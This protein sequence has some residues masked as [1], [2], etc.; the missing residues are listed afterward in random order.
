[1]IKSISIKDFALINKKEIDFENGFNV[2]TGETGAGKSILISAINFVLGER[3]DKSKIR[4]GCDCAQVQVVFETSNAKVLDTL[5]NFGFETDNAI[6]IN[7]K[8][9]GDGHSDIRLNGNLITLSMLRKITTNLVDVYGQ[10]EH[11]SL[12]DISKHIEYLDEY[13]GVE[14]FE[15][16]KELSI[17]FDEMKIVKQKINSFGGDEY[18]RAREKDMLLYQVK[19]IEEADLKAEEEDELLVLKNK[20]ENCQ[21]IF[22]T[23][24]TTRELLSEMPSNSICDNLYNAS[25]M[26]GTI[27]SIDSEF[28]Q[29]TERLNS[30]QIEAKDIAETLEQKIDEYNFNEYDFDKVDSRLDLIKNL[31]RKYGSSIDEILTFYQNSKL[32]LNEL[33]DTEELLA[34]YLESEDKLNKKIKAKCGELAE[35]RKKGAID[36]EKSIT[37]ELITLGM[38]NAKFCIDFKEVA[39]TINGTDSIEFMFSA[40]LG[41]PFKP[42]SK[43]ISGGEMSRFMLAFKTVMG[44]IE[45]VDTMIF[46]EIDSGMSGVTSITVG[47]KMA[48]LSKNVQVFAIT[49]LATIASFADAHYQIYK[50]VCGDKTVSNIVKL[51]AN[52]QLQEISRLAGGNTNSKIGLEHARELRDNAFAFISALK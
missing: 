18:S 3:A 32:R 30:I 43:V 25:K 42:L 16:K 7:R 19:E 2:I 14:V 23:V 13:L 20:M 21:R 10:H 29:L 17:L 26:L 1:M 45:T 8:I 44:N 49:H 50:Q 33:E 27:N 38:P 39:P 40:N 48:V 52:S 9:Y 11:Q 28:E 47:Q 35:I 34:K 24:R 6:I 46:D 12:L 31:K 5:N 36:F 37:N 4:F 22:D 15:K 51:D 41:E